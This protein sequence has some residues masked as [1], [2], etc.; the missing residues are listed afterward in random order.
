MADKSLGELL[1]RAKLLLIAAKISDEFSG[2]NYTMLEILY[3]HLDQVTVQLDPKRP[4]AWDDKL[5]VLRVIYGSFS[6]PIPVPELKALNRE[7]AA[8]VK[9]K[10]EQNQKFQLETQNWDGY[11]ACHIFPQPS[12]SEVSEQ[13][14][15]WANEPTHHFDKTSVIFDDGDRMIIMVVRSYEFFGTRG[16]VAYFF[17]DPAATSEVVFE[18]PEGDSNDSFL[19]YTFSMSYGEIN[20]EKKIFVVVSGKPE[21]E[22]FDRQVVIV[23]AFD[24]QHAML[25]AQIEPD[26]SWVDGPHAYTQGDMKEA[27]HFTLHRVVDN[28]Y[29][30]CS[31]VSAAGFDDNQA[32][33]NA[34]Y[35][36]SK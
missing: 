22:L 4:Q 10:M 30:F 8:K 5:A 9:N 27:I 29:N 28:S 1:K 31:K 32:I 14:H 35:S 16:Q 34:V 15:L 24:P 13:A 21:G 17:Y 6:F 12:R 19:R 26:P 11:S 18:E 3:Y 25:L 33:V 36:E 2:L 7:L 20:L 23:Q